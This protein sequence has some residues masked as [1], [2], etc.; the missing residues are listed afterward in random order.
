MEMVR[1][2]PREN[3]RHSGKNFLE[4]PEYAIRHKPVAGETN[5]VYVK[6]EICP[7]GDRHKVVCNVGSSILG[8]TT[9]LLFGL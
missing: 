2:V 4:M 6:I 3:G 7:L 5:G 1:L 9:W 8:I